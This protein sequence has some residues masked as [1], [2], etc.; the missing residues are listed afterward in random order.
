MNEGDLIEVWWETG[1]VSTQG[2]N[3]AH[4]LSIKPYKGK[5]K[6]HF[7]HTVTLSALHTRSRQVEMSIS[8]NEC[9]AL[10]GLSYL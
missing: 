8:K 9:G 6:N 10:A 4:V 3:L 2:K 7:A 1:I 5:Y